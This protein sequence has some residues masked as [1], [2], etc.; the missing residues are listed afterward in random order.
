VFLTKGN[1]TTFGEYKAMLPRQYR[2]VN[3]A[4][5]FLVQNPEETKQAHGDLLD[6]IV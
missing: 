1:K 5:I 6:F 2:S 4:A 3:E